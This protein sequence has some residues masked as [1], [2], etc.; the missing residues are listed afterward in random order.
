[1]I[2]FDERQPPS[3]TTILLLIG[4]GGAGKS[5]VGAK[6]APLLNRRLIDLDQEF[7]RRVGDIGPFIRGEGYEAYK[8]RNSGLAAEIANEI[9]EPTLF[10]TSSGF[11]TSDNPKMAL[12]ANRKLLASAYSICLLPSRDIESSVN[13]IVERQLARPFSG[14]AA[15]EEEIIRDRYCTYATLGDLII[16]ST[17]SA[18]DI[19]LAVSG[20]F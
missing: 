4:P 11:L 9:A 7:I 17:E 5:S 1:M 13:I 16:F 19:A 20:R 2:E 10:V 18:N 8:V 12:D 15:R 6:L 14:D 3:D